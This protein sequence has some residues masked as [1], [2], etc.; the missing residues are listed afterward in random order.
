[1]KSYKCCNR[2]LHYKSGLGGIEM[3]LATERSI[4]GSLS[5]SK[6]GGGHSA[7]RACRVPPNRVSIGVR[8]V[9]AL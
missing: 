8:T 4:F 6:D 7:I 2:M 5:G 3:T 9:W 1:M